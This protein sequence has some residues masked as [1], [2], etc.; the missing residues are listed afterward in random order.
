MT[1]KPSTI[2][3]AWQPFDHETPGKY[4]EA[5]LSMG[6]ERWK[7]FLSML[8][9]LAMPLANPEMC[10]SRREQCFQGSVQSNQAWAAT[11]R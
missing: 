2:C 8:R 10:F 11:K 4:T 9:P 6:A 5:D 1:S 3:T 7:E